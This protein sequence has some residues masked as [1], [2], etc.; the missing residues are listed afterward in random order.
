MLSKLS[1]FVVVVVS[2]QISER[3]NFV[4]DFTDKF[5][6][7][8]Q[9]SQIVYDFAGKHFTY[10]LPFNM[11]S[12]YTYQGSLTVPPYSESVTWIVFTNRMFM[13]ER[14]VCD[15]I[16]CFFFHKKIISWNWYFFQLMNLRQLRDEKN[17]PISN[18]FRKPQP[19]NKRKIYENSSKKNNKKQL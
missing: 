17:N 2:C 5:N 3:D 4:F 19:L 6:Q 12:Y 16:F 7:I 13:S 10:F 9:P 1:F 15:S 14:Q 8:T 11:N 18:N